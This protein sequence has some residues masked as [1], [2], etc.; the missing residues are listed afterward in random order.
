MATSYASEHST[1]FCSVIML[2]RD[3]EA[4]H[5]KTLEDLVCSLLSHAAGHTYAHRAIPYLVDTW[6]FFYICC[7]WYQWCW[8]LSLFSGS[9]PPFALIVDMYARLAFTD[10]TSPA[11]ITRT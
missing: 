4:L 10:W 1:H 9:L 6:M 8:F 5:T 7:I 2:S 3:H 11:A